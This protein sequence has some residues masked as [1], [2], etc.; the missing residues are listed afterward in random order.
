MRPRRER[1]SPTGVYYLLEAVSSLFFAMLSTA[2]ALY[3]IQVAHLNALQLILVGTTLELSALIF[4]VPTGVLADTV[5]RRLSV[6]VGLA[7]AGVGFLLWG[8]VPVFASIIAAQVIWAIGYTFISGA[9]E[10]WIADEV[11]AD[12][13]GRVYMR[14][15]QLAYAAAAVGIVGSV[16]IG[17]VFGLAA[18]LLV[19]G[20]GHIGLAVV[21]MRVMPEANFRPAPRGERTRRAHFAGTFRASLALLRSSPVLLTILAISLIAGAASETFDRLWEFHLLDHF[22]FPAVPELPLIAWFGIIN[23]TGLLMGFAALEVLR[24]Q[25]DTD[26]HLG[27]ARAL[28]AI[29]VVLALALIGFGLAGNLALAIGFYLTARL[30]RRLATPIRL[31]WIN[32]GLTSNVRATV[33]SMDGQADAIGQIAGGPLLGWLAAAAGTRVAMVAVG[34][35]LAPAVWLYLRTIRLHG[36]DLADVPE[37]LPA[38]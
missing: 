28:L 36:R 19:A 4:E 18:P 7:L 33:I 22:S 23:V 11:G 34:L 20:A 30:M 10:A 15:S 24:R 26:S 32:Q 8:A 37:D 12:G 17:S 1:I 3:G 21:L 31:A 29:D 13:I 35:M 9:T 6:I 25:L 5:S 14:A 38:E 2:G 27:A 16:V